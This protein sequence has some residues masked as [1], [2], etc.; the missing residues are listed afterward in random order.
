VTARAQSKRRILGF[1]SWTLMMIASPIFAQ[2]ELLVDE[3]VAVVNKHVI[4]RSE[5]LQ[6][7]LLIQLERQGQA[8]AGGELSTEFLNQ[9]V[10]FLINQRVILDEGS[11]L[12]LPVVSVAEQEQMLVGLKKRFGDPKHFNRF[13]TDN[14]LTEI[15]IGEV[16]VRHLMVDR[17]KENKIKTLPDITEEEVLRFYQKNQKQF[18]EAQLSAVKEAIRLRLMTQQRE[19]VMARWL[20]ELRKRAEVKILVESAD[21]PLPGK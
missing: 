9:I 14:V 7:A 1:I 18:G 20:Q 8:V 6:E 2:E 15:D 4:T 16:L 12:G 5:V 13:L 3:V 10:E 17:L 11:Q 19:K 21:H